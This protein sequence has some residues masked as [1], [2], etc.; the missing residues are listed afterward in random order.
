MADIIYSTTE[1]HTSHDHRGPSHTHTGPQHTHGAE[2]YAPVQ[3]NKNHMRGLFEVFIVD[4]ETASLVA[5]EHVVANDER[6]AQLKGALS[7][8]LGDVDDYDFIV[9]RLGDVRAKKKAS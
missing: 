2:R 5:H 8:K 6:S 3:E 9:R 4:P 1:V 7:A